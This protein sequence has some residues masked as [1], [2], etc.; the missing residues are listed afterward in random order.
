[1]SKVFLVDQNNQPFDPIHPGYARLL[2]TSSKAA[3]SRRYPFTLILKVAVEQPEVRPLRRKID[4][5][6]KTTG[7]ALVNDASGEVLFAAELFHRGQAIR[8]ALSRRRA[9]RR[10]RRGRGS[11]AGR[12]GSA[13]RGGCHPLLRVGSPTS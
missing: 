6:S 1:M 13:Q 7:L 9:V 5:G 12:T 2:L 8:S 11:R 10:G 4:P 3:V